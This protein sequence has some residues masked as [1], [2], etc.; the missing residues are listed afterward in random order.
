VRVFERGRAQDARKLERE[1]VL[2]QVAEQEGRQA[3]LVRCPL[4]IGDGAL[5]GGVQGLDVD[6]RR[7]GGGGLLCARAAIQARERRVGHGGR[8]RHVHVV[9]PDCAGHWGRRAR[10]IVS[11]AGELRGGEV[12]EWSRVEARGERRAQG[13]TSVG[14]TRGPRERDAAAE[15]AKTRR[16]RCTGRRGLEAMAV[17][18]ASGRGVRWRIDASTAWGDGG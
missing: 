6:A 16:G 8:R 5:D 1:L 10:A 14:G 11:A 4:G 18:N 7:A 13:V 17:A 9:G 3:R 2:V 12:V 15:G